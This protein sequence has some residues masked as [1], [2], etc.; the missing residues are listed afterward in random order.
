MTR[1]LDNGPWKILRALVREGE[2][3]GKALRQYHYARR[4]QDGTFLDELCDLGLIE[5]TG[6]SVD[7]TADRELARKP[8]QFR[9]MYKLTDAGRLAAEYGEYEY[10]PVRPAA[11][12]PR[13]G[14]PARAAASAGTRRRTTA[15]RA[16]RGRSR[17]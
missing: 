17:L 16:A 12:A 15:A 5:P 3:S 4:T 2:L 9:R 10:T 6:R 7:A 11:P 14:P 8:A 1:D 13:S